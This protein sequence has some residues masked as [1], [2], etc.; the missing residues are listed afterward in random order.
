MAML[1]ISKL[2]DSVQTNMYKPFWNETSSC[3]RKLEIY[4]HDFKIMNLAICQN[5][6]LIQSSIVRNEEQ[7][8][9]YL[10]NNID[11]M[12]VSFKVLHT[13]FCLSL[14]TSVVIFKKFT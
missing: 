5:V 8:K 1:P 9:T 2:L 12:N 7:I 4:C 14:N 11:K 13:I 10:F 6:Q 3:K